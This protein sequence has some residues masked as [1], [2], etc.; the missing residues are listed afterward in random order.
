M[1]LRYKLSESEFTE[2]EDYQN[3]PQ[4]FYSANS[5]IL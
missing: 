1:M 4:M 3:L 5:K 2:L